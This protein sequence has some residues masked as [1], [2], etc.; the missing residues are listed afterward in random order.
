MSD[1]CSAINDGGKRCRGTKDIT[2][3]QIYLHGDGNRGSLKLPEFA[4]INLCPKHFVMKHD[5]NSNRYEN[6]ED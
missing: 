3:A 5:S 4:V 6:D 1:Q 2:R